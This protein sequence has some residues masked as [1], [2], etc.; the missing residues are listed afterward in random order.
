MPLQMR[1]TNALNFLHGSS[2]G[3]VEAEIMLQVS[4]PCHNTRFGEGDVFGWPSS[5]SVNIIFGITNQ[6]KN[7][8]LWILRQVLGEANLC[9]RMVRTVFH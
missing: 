7:N 3:G 8:I 5:R 2:D 4:N 6:G 1:G 9:D